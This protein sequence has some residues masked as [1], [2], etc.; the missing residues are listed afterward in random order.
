MFDS[1]AAFFSKSL[2]RPDHSTLWGRAVETAKGATHAAADYLSEPKDSTDLTQKAGKIFHNLKESI[3]NVDVDDLFGKVKDSTL[4]D[5]NMPDLNDWREKGATFVDSARE[6]GTRVLSDSAA[7]LRQFVKH[8]SFDSYLLRIRGFGNWCSEHRIQ[9][10]IIALVILNPSLL[11]LPVKLL[12]R[13]LGFGRQG[14]VRGHFAPNAQRQLY[15][16]RVPKN[17]WFARSQAAAMRP[18]PEESRSLLWAAIKTALLVSA[19]AY[20]IPHQ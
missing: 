17:G 20:M 13:L 6:A 7:H 3:T 1:V 9:A 10:V 4:K 16:G 15:G 12:L 19:V 18:Q 5:R 14:P 2:D 8:P 11:F